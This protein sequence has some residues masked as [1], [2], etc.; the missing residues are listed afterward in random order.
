MRPNVFIP[1]SPKYHPTWESDEMKCFDHR[2]SDL[3]KCLHPRL[4]WWTFRAGLFAMEMMSSA[5]QSSRWTRK[6]T[7]LER[8]TANSERESGEYFEEKNI[9]TSP[10]PSPAGLHRP[11]LPRTGLHH[12]DGQ[13]LCYEVNHFTITNCNNKAKNIS[14][15]RKIFQIR[16]DVHFRSGETSTD[17][18]TWQRD[19]L[20]GTG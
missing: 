15:L 18:E 11:V 4:T 14:I 6:K 19:Y 3:T 7:L 10:F 8:E 1:V 13:P 20:T 16:L 2:I 5:L 9:V 12:L 17:M